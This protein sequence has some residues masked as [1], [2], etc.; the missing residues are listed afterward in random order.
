MRLNS[1]MST[2]IVKSL[3]NI[4]IDL[5]TF[6]INKFNS[7]YKLQNKKNL[8]RENIANITMIINNINFLN[9]DNPIGHNFA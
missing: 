7:F 1:L 9:T 6:L 5:I 8:S 3:K 4:Y 2:I